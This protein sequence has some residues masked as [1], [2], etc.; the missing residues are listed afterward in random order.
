VRFKLV[1][2]PEVVAALAEAEE[3]YRGAVN[4]FLKRLFSVRGPYR[5]VPPKRR[6]EGK[7]IA[8]DRTVE[9]AW[10]GSPGPL[11]RECGDARL[12][13][14]ALRKR[15]I[16]T[17]WRTVPAPDSVYVAVPGISATLADLAWGQ[18]EAIMKSWLSNRERRWREADR[19]A[20]ELREWREGKFGQA[21]E[22]R[23]LTP[24]GIRRRIAL[25]EWRVRRLRRD[26]NPP[27]FRGG[28]LNLP[29]TVVFLDEET[30]EMRLEGKRLTAKVVVDVRREQSREFLADRVRWIL[31]MQ[32]EGIRPYP[33]LLM[34][35][36]ELYLEYPLRSLRLV[37]SPESSFAAV[38]VCKGYGALV[39]MAAVSS[40][41]GKPH[42]L[43]L[44]KGDEVRRRMSSR[45]WLRRRLQLI[46]ARARGEGRR[47][48]LWRKLRS[49]KKESDFA[50]TEAHR[51]AREVVRRVR[52]IFPDGHAVIV[53]ERSRGQGSWSMSKR[54]EQFIRYKAI[55]EG[56][57]VVYV[58]RGGVLTS[59][60]KCGFD[61]PS[62]RRGGYFKCGRCGYSLNANLNAA[63]NLANRFYEPSARPK[64]D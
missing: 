14:F 18:A 54:V 19:L 15:F 6:K 11:C 44:D 48:R 47:Y 60:S 2:P 12:G 33:R 39:A 53:M 26:P 13:W 49:M 62:N 43:W 16:P 21:P 45:K 58:P 20:E 36:G 8:C 24:A 31:R 1:A 41:H 40:P 9:I 37:P 51:V 57:P 7:C 30:V 17:K 28:V 35:E 25:L 59:C 63:I 52:E 42:H 27:R 29:N 23:P 32:A 64:S 34:R 4:F 55:E 56:I 3:A 46:A 61:S 10:V 50:K 5:N 22:R 38:G